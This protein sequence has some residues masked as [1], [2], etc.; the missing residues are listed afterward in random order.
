M[1]LIIFRNTTRRRVF[2]R[3][4]WKDALAEA[5]AEFRESLSPPLADSAA[6]R[7]AGVNLRPPHKFM[8]DMRD[9]FRFTLWLYSRLDGRPEVHGARRHLHP[10]GIFSDS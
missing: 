5:A 4:S 7:P 2:R 6:V 9:L 3:R 8:Y 1:S 10:A